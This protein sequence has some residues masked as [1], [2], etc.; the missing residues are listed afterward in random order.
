MQMMYRIDSAG[1][2][3]YMNPSR[4]VQIDRPGSKSLPQRPVHSQV[5]P[6]NVPEG[7]KVDVPEVVITGGRASYVFAIDVRSGDV[8]WQFPAQ[9]QLL[10]SIA[11]VGKDVYAPTSTGRLHALDLET[12]KEK[13]EWLSGNV[14]NVKRFVSASRNR[15]YVLDMQGR[16][17]CLDRT[18]GASIFVYD[19]RRFEHCLFNLE[20]DQIILLSDSGLVQCLREQ[21]I[22]GVGVLY[23]RISSVEYAST[24]R[25]GE[26][27]TLWWGEGEEAGVQ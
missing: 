1:Q 8:R 17:V 11:V 16:L 22:L 23:H 15:L 5:Y 20:T 13:E 3:F 4:F 14:R 6:V 2:T 10:E 24:V 25:G 27:P 18:T 9:G 19:I 21:D 12:G 7:E 26:M